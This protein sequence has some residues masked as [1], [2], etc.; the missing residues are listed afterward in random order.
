MAKHLIKIFLIF[1]QMSTLLVVV[2][3]SWFAMILLYGALFYAHGERERKH[4]SV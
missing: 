3:I 4:K 2:A 1:S